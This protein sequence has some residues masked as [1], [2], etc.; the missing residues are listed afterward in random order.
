MPADPPKTPA[1]DVPPEPPPEDPPEPPKPARARCCCRRRPAS[2]PKV[3]RAAI[4]WVCG[5]VGWTVAGLRGS[6]GVRRSRCGES[7]EPAFVKGTPGEPLRLFPGLICHRVVP[8][9]ASSFRCTSTTRPRNVTSSAITRRRS[10][11]RA[12]RATALSP[13]AQ[14]AP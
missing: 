10:A 8:A 11:V 14:A 9:T 4:C 3:G 6:R 1:G 12:S 2:W 13:P 5:E 7:C